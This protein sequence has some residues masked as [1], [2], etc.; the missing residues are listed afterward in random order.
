MVL[1]RKKAE[2]VNWTRCGADDGIAPMARSGI[3]KHEFTLESSTERRDFAV[4]LLVFS[5]WSGC[6]CYAGRVDGDRW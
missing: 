2:Q 1:T 5:R 3:L 6:D 4:A